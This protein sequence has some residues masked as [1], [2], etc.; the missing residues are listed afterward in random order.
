MRGHIVL[1]TPHD[2]CSP[3][4]VAN[5]HIALARGLATRNVGTR[6]LIAGAADVPALRNR[7][8][9][10]SWRE[11]GGRMQ[12]LPHLDPCGLVAVL[13]VGRD[14]LVLRRGRLAARHA[15]VPALLELTEFPDVVV[16]RRAGRSLYLRA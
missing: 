3:T 14:P 2:Y 9:D 7:L 1:V 13:C 15:G 6:F 5:R 8:P 11:T 4:A 12:G 16:P 10:F